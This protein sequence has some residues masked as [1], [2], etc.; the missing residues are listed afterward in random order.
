[1]G[2]I[3]GIYC[4]SLLIISQ[5]RILDMTLGVWVLQYKSSFS[6]F[7]ALFL[8]IGCLNDSRAI[9]KRKINVLCIK[10]S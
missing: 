4:S 2:C 5:W 9:E 6:I 7:F 1:M 8:L 10:K 3:T